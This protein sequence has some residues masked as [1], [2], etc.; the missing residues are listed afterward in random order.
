MQN[1][2]FKST[3]H[4][5]L[6]G[7]IPLLAFGGIAVAEMDEMIVTADFRNK[8]EFET[9][10]SVSV[11]GEEEI[12]KRAAQHMEDLVNV[13]PNVNFA[14][15]SGRARFFQIRG[16]GE[17]SQF[18][19][20]L[21]HSVGI[22]IDNVD[23]SGAGTA[24]TLFDVEQVEI[25]RG[26]QGTRYGA[27]ALAGLINIKTKGPEREFGGHLRASAGDYGSSSVGVAVTGPLSDVV[28]YRL[29]G[30]SFQSDGYTYNAFLDRD[31][32]N[33]RDEVT[34]RGRL[35]FDWNDRSQTDVVLSRVDLDNGYDEFSLDNS[36]TTLS[37][38]PGH[39][40]Q[41]SDFFSIQ[42]EEE[43]NT[44]SV[45]LIGTNSHSDIEYGYDEDWSF[46][47]IHPS[48][49]T[50]T[51]NYIRE[52]SNS[53]A[54][55]RLISKEPVSFFGR[56]TD[57]LVGGFRLDSSV[58]LLRQ[59]TFAESDFTS[60]YDFTTSAIFFQI[61]TQ[62]SDSVE[63]TSGLRWEKRESN[64][65]DS[66]G[67]EFSPDTGMW[68][69]QIALRFLT[70]KN[71]MPYLSLA[72]GYKAG[73][74]NTDGTLDEDL[75]GFD[76]EFLWEIEGGIKGISSNGAIRYR[77]AAFYDSRR[78]QQVK[79]YVV[80]V[81]ADGSTEFIDLVG[82]AAEGTNLGIEL[83]MDFDVSEVL[84][85]YANA[86]LL[87]AEFDEFINEYGEDLSGRDQAQAPRYMLSIGLRYESASWFGDLGADVK[88]SFF[89]SDGDSLMSSSNTLINARI[90]YRQ[91][92]W[93]ANFWG[94]NLTDEQV[95]IDGFASFGND[96]RKDY[97]T[98]PY[99]QF[100]EPRM[101]GLTLEMSL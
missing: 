44:L 47:G 92:N 52:R 36:G 22:L 11:L 76:S 94:R 21:N 79:S 56:R 30:E 61:D 25:L 89:F 78:D 16:I 100:G 43:F 19:D 74:F 87:R 41:T 60:T 80:R 90:G 59:Y 64:Y 66:N 10:Q 17:R 4:L 84:A 95:V 97:I 23:F 28:S 26:P 70:S 24:A 93:T 7:A 65:L 27:N 33:A 9:P 96:P 31:D 3:A 34:L 101:L 2:L 14:G 51:D 38:E 77:A 67:V 85:L 32:V 91:D 12:D 63:M 55:V 49:Y 45:V 46:T 68:G 69:G 20:P 83:E 58:D 29:A 57:W 39:D 42:H 73:G 71:S 40:R 53:S 88:D 37:D 5:K 54:E 6:L 62:L 82:N 75:R 98:E 72:R 1:H 99:I 8:S 48:G 86:G 35:R 18:G 50:S 15:G 81:R 13:V